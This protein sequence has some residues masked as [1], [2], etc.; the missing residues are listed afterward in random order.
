MLFI[1]KFMILQKVEDIYKEFS[2]VIH[3][4][5]HDFAVHPKIFIKKLVLLFIRKFMILQKVEDIY[6]E[7]SVVIHKKIHD[8][9]EGGR[10]L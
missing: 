1:R 9:A 7:F 2:D 5:I 3:K 10:Y 6:K 4:K 8:F